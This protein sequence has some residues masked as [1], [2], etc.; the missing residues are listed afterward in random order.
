MNE[1]N[2]SLLNLPQL[3]EIQSQ[4]LE[5][6]ERLSARVLIVGDVGL[7]EYLLGE[8][9]R[10]SPEAPVPILDVKNQEQR[11]GLA[12]N[13]AQNVSSLGGEAILLSVVGKDEAGLC[14]K[15]LLDKAGVSTQHLV[16]DLNRPTTRK[17]R[18]ISEN[19]HIARLDF[20]RRQFLSGSVESQLIELATHLIPSSDVIVI[21]DYAKG[22]LSKKTL[23]RVI[24]LAHTAGKRILIDPAPKTPVNYYRGADIVTPNRN[25]ALNLADLEVD[26]FQEET[27]VLLKA[28]AILMGQLQC[29]SLV[30]TRGK[31]GMSLFSR[32]KV[33]HLPTCARE[34][35]DITGAGDTVIAALS[36]GIASGMNLEQACVLAN[37]AAGVVVGQVGCVSCSL[38]ELTQY[39]KN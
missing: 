3:R 7:D 32:G 9:S 39:I 28:G 17:V 33:I 36:L 2:E 37:F 29:Q 18:L 26:G 27:E 10:I 30:M 24:E 31:D 14:L 1:L 16:E 11:I 34:V 12:A 20:E 38:Q 13:V 21:E 19:H 35:Y 6:L 22:V 8:V 25:E 23:R 5:S 4:I 15:K